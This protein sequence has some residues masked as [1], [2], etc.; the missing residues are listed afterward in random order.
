MELRWERLI[1]AL[2]ASFSWE[3]PCVF[4]RLAIIRPSSMNLFRL[5]NST[6]LLIYCGPLCEDFF[7]HR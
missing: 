7:R 2:S 5:L 6:S 4:R 3:I 1:F